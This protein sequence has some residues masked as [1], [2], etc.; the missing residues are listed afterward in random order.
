M[1]LGPWHDSA[2]VTWRTLSA[3][4]LKARPHS[5]ELRSAFDAFDGGHVDQ[6]HQIGLSLL[7]DDIDDDVALMVTVLAHLRRLE[8]E[9]ARRGADQLLTLKA[10]HWA[11]Q[12]VHAWVLVAENAGAAAV[13]VAL[14]AV[15]LA[16]D[17]VDVVASAAEILAQVNGYR[18]QT[19]E[20]AKR[21]LK[22][23]PQCTSARLTLAQ[24][25]CQRGDWPTAI[26]LFQGAVEIEP[27]NHEARAQLATAQRCFGQLSAS[28]QTLSELA[29]RAP[30]SRF[31]GNVHEKQE[32][33]SSL[34]FLSSIY[35][36]AFAMFALLVGAVLLGSWP[37]AIGL[38]VVGAVAVVLK[39]TA[40]RSTSA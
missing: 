37:L 34:A 20:Y 24:L 10:D 14:E 25:H 9:P 31:L 23:D 26:E 13:D 12:H 6:A 1:F 40:L 7:A 18:S 15:E 4:M 5:A 11:A 17:N 29:E 21:S 8:V 38:L 36:Y 30:E 22:L 35:K 33:W 19:R 3:W 39:S 27:D 32:L 16:P 2:E 28:K